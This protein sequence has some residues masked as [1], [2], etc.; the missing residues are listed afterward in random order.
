MCF[1]SVWDVRVRSDAISMRVCRIAFSTVLVGIPQ[2][3]GVSLG[4]EM[5]IVRRRT[6]KTVNLIQIIGARFLGSS[7]CTVMVQLY[8]AS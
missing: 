1:V 2:F 8:S 6:R 4:F 5:A 3:V 7:A